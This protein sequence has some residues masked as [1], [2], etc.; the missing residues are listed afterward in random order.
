MNRLCK[1]CHISKPIEEFGIN[2]ECLCGHVYT[3]RECSNKVLRHNRAEKR[4]LLPPKLN[5]T[6]KVCK[7]CG[8]VLDRNEFPIAYISRYSGQPILDSRCKKCDNIYWKEW[9]LRNKE[10]IK[11]QNNKESSK[12]SRKRYRDAHK[13]ET[14]IYRITHREEFNANQRK[15]NKT[16][17]RRKY[18]RIYSKKKREHNVMFKLYVDLRR[19]MLLAVKDG[20]GLDSDIVSYLGCDINFLKEYLESKFEYGMTWENHT[21]HGWHI[22]HIYP[23]GKARDREHLIELMHY[24][25]LQPLWAKD[26]MSKGAKIIAA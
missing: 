24:T 25:N 7:C 18:N 10:K 21:L 6:T 13:E 16:E 26:N 9:R 1:K 20:V 5:P 4:K 15:Y 8:E 19:R 23:L 12:K 22:D 14:K 3:C 2:K 17:K 11:K